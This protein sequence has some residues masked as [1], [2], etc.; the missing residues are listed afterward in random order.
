MI[1]SFTHAVSEKMRWAILYF[2]DI[3]DL[4]FVFVFAVRDWM[5]NICVTHVLGCYSSEL[6]L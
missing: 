2:L 5:Y 3:N 4:Y 6:E 1:G